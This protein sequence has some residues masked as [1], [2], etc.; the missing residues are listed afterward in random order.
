MV[1]EIE[2]KEGLPASKLAVPRVMLRDQPSLEVQV[3]Q[4]SYC[5][6]IKRSGPAR[7]TKQAQEQSVS[8]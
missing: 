5:L 6:G 7:A 8:K 3:H 1:I 4:P 2:K